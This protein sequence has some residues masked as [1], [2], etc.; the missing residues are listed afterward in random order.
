MTIPTRAAS[1]STRPN[2]LFASLAAK[3]GASN[4]SPRWLRKTVRGFI[5]ICLRWFV[6]IVQFDHFRQNNQNRQFPAAANPVASLIAIKMDIS[7]QSYFL[8]RLGCPLSKTA[9]IFITG[10]S[11]AVRL[12]P[13]FRF[14]EKEVYIRRDP[15]TGDV[16]LSRRPVSW[17]G[18]FALDATTK[19]PRDFMSKADRRQGKQSRDPFKVK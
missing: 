17:D 11:Q 15:A 1:S 5:A 3:V 6:L 10:R 12:P 7:C 16:I 4:V 13:E 14:E 8:H 2:A 19:V 18:F 9:K